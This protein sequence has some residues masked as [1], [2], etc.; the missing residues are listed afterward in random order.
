MKKNLH[1]NL[2]LEKNPIHSPL[3]KLWF[4]KDLRQLLTTTTTL[5][6][7]CKTFKLDEKV[8]MGYDRAGWKMKLQYDKQS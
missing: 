4:N 7:R 2:H 3:S 6:S 8:R 5:Y 1:T